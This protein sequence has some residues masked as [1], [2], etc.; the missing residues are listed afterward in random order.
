MVEGANLGY[1][2]VA[3]ICIWIRNNIPYSPGTSDTPLSAFEV[4]KQG[5]GV[6]RDLAHLRI[7]LCRSISI[8]T[9]MVVGYLYGLEP[10]DLHA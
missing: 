4:Y 1:D 5:H 3:S 9:R 6:C 2:Q 7:A 8:P 10:M